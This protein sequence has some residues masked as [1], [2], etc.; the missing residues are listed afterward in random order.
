VCGIR[1]KRLDEYQNVTSIGEL[2]E[3]C[4]ILAY[5]KAYA[6]YIFKKCPHA[7]VKMGN[8]LYTS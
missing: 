3:I 4:I 5:F 6:K 2:V 7:L 8:I 1:Q